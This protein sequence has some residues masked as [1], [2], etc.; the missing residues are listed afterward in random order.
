[1]KN[2]IILEAETKIEDKELREWVSKM[3]TQI[4]TINERTKKHTKDIMELKRK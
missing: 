4:E 1:M 3:Q 2:K